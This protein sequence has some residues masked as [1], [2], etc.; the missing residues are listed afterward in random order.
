MYNTQN[1]LPPLGRRLGGLPRRG[2]ESTTTQHGT[3]TY[4]E[5]VVRSSNHADI[6]ANYFFPSGYGMPILMKASNG[7]AI[8]YVAAGEGIDPNNRAKLLIN[9][10]KTSFSL[11]ANLSGYL[12]GS[13]SVS[14]A[15]A[16]TVPLP[17]FGDTFG[18]VFLVS[19]STSGAVIGAIKNGVY[20]EKLITHGTYQP[21]VYDII[22][23]GGY[24]YVVYG[25]SASQHVIV[26]IDSSWAIVSKKYTNPGNAYESKRAPQ[27]CI[28]NAG[29][30]HT[31]GY[32][33]DLVSYV[34]YIIA[35]IGANTYSD[36]NLSVTGSSSQKAHASVI[37]NS[38]GGAYL[39]F[40]NS[41]DGL[42]HF[43]AI[44]LYTVDD[45]GNRTIRLSIGQALDS[46]V[47]AESGAILL[48]EKSG[49][50]LV[51]AMRSATNGTLPGIQIIVV[52]E[53][54]YSVVRNFIVTGNLNT[55][56]TPYLNEQSY[57]ALDG[58][59]V[60]IGRAGSYPTNS[61]W[62]VRVPYL[63]SDNKY[64]ASLNASP[65][66][67][68][69]TLFF[70]INDLIESGIFTNTGTSYMFVSAVNT[71]VALSDSGTTISNS[72]T[73]SMSTFSD[74]RI[75]SEEVVKKVSFGSNSNHVLT[76]G[77]RQ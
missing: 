43:K 12:I 11:S 8:Y 61:V 23:N 5:E 76:I 69:P 25:I 75:M 46:T 48:F 27:S 15:T 62:Q 3:P 44:E 14:T 31:L 63:Y 42:P 67:N 30:V 22:E 65:A 10:G 17:S 35:N 59:S 24:L 21:T 54:D 45:S 20:T 70:S 52:R 38:A 66:G 37:K 2:S 77:V 36:W 64:E 51:I 26:K 56:G 34:R 55:T 6:S 53:S 58:D 50:Y 19:V 73:F 13:A 29:V 9:F 57:C 18:F 7:N 68:N 71:N 41:A 74:D 60:V 32:R 33:S 1:N 40:V 39:L 28:S 49:D 4:F 16:N 72:S 47:T